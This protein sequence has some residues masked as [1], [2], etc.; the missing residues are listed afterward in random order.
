MTCHDSQ[1]PLTEVRRFLHCNYN[2]NDAGP[3][4]R[5]YTEL[6][7]LRP[8]MRTTSAGSDG[9]PFGIYGETA[10][11]TVFLYDHRGGRYSN[12]LELVQWTQPATFGNPYPHAW[13]NGIHSIAYT[14][15]DLDAVALTAERLGGTLVRRGRWWLL[16]RDPEGV[17]VEV[18]SVDG[19]SEVRYLRIVCSDLDR[20][21]DWWQQ[22]GFTQAELSNVAGDEIWPAEGDRHVTAEQAIVG[23]DDASFGVI[24]T[25]WSGPQPTGP[26][27]AMPFH[28]GLYRMAM[29]V[30]DIHSTYDAL[31]AAGI[32][33]Q[34]PY[35]F[36][37][38]GTKLTDGLTIMFIRDPDGI[39]VEL[40]D[41]PRVGASG[42]T[43]G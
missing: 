43:Q 9:T 11:E 19:P 5:F 37:L 1:M 33:R 38:P 7:G 39:L 6:F 18:H 15:T 41:R 3:L 12:S 40:V 4:E 23:T 13:C 29:A 42:S 25:T 21:L 24:F 30:D 8:V 10:S 26:T 14:A 20:T 27:Y 36:Q 16:L 2:C 28:H 34:P 32:P 35:T 17:A 31:L 22:L